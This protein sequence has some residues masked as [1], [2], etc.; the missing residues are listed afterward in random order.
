[1][2]SYQFSVQRQLF[3]RT[4]LDVGYVGNYGVHEEILQDLNQAVPNAAGGSLS[5]QSR[6][7]IAAYAGIQESFNEGVSR[8]NALE[9]KLEKRLGNGI[10]LANSFTWSHAQDE[11]AADQE[12]NN[13]DSPI[14]NL[15]DPLGSYTRS[16]YDRPLNDSLA[17]VWDLPFGKD[18]LFGSHAGAPLQFALSGWQVTALNTYV[19]GLPINISYSP[20]TAQQVSNLTSFLY[21]PN[22]VGV[23]VLA[24]GNRT[25]IAPGQ[26]QYLDPT[27][28]SVPTA[29]NTPFGNCP[30]NVARTPGFSDLDLGLHKRFPLGFEKA[31]L[32]FR[33]EA[34]N[35]LNHS[36]A[37]A[38]DSV[39][40]DSSYG[41]VSSYYPSRELQVALKLVF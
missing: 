35:V 24:G 21:R 2:Q 14:V 13:N 39:A 19:S 40:T 33:A 10:Y 3:N 28:I 18:L 6:R 38:P 7:P 20:A 5:L 4:Y 15:N 16:A 41:V 12:L 37:Q 30:R 8:Y 31:G 23:P 26:Y 1:V 29:A 17:V 9:A 22:L 27:A 32:E 11:A 34:F 36:N 25:A